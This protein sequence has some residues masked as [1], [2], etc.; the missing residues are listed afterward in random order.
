[1]I[2]DLVQDMPAPDW[3]DEDKR[4]LWNAQVGLLVREG[5]LREV[6]SWAL[7]MMVVAVAGARECAKQIQQDGWEI[8]NTITG[9]FEQR[10]P[11]PLIG[12][13]RAFQMDYL[14][15]CNQFGLTPS[16]R[17]SLGIQ[18][19]KGRKLLSGIDQKIGPAEA[20]PVAAVEVA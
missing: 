17:I 14:K 7:E 18:E 8:L 11:H 2:S 6:D 10:Q 5:V 13:M 4:G 1:M 12:P 20:I 19:L 9:G 3:F 15:W 16:A